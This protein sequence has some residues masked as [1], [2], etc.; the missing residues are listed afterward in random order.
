MKAKSFGICPYRYN[1]GKIEILLCKS[2]KNSC[3]GFVKGKREYGETNKETATR[4][5]MEE[6]GVKV[7]KKYLEDKFCQKN[8]NKDVCIYL[9]EFIN[10]EEKFKLNRREIYS[11]EWISIDKNIDIC[12]NQK[13]IFN[14]IVN[15]LNKKLFWIKNV[16]KG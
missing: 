2:S 7:E 9:L 5:F 10:F 14:Q 6:V 3:Y 15:F 13:E 11:I 4:E 1:N 8:K 16:I 12:K